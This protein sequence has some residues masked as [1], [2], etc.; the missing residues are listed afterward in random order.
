MQH[1]QMIGRC[2]DLILRRLFLSIEVKFNG[3]LIECCTD[4][5]LKC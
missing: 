4:F 3:S 1:R 5:L 2:S